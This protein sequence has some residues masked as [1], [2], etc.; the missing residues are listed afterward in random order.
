MQS[1]E[2]ICWKSDNQ[3]GVAISF[4]PRAL[5]LNHSWVPVLLSFSSFDYKIKFKNSFIRGLL[6]RS[7]HLISKP[8]SKR[9][10]LCPRIKK[11]KKKMHLLP[12][13]SSPQLECR[14]DWVEWGLIL[15]LTHLLPGKLISVS[16]VHDSHSCRGHIISCCKT[17]QQILVSQKLKQGLFWMA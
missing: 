12:G 8:I 11:K 5:L 15:A 10:F 16:K 13:W 3:Q 2:V 17:H 4:K 1:C 9:H 7:N 14:D 6:K